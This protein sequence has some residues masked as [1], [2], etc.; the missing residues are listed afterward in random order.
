MTSYTKTVYVADEG[1]VFDYKEPNKHFVIV[2]GEVIILHLY[3]KQIEFT[4]GSEDSIDN[5]VE[6][7]DPNL[8]KGE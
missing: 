4:E 6:V 5:Y 1:K 2:D 3:S 8:T 7:T